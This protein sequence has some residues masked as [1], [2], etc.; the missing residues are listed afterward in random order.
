MLRKV[1]VIGGAGFIGS[2]LVELLIEN[3]FFPVVIDNFST[4]KRSNLPPGGV[5]IRDY[6]ITEDPKRL[7]GIIKG[8]ECVFHLAALTSV[9][10]SLDHPD[11]YTKVNVVGTANVLEACRIAGVKKLV[12]SST[13]AIYGNTATFPTDETQQPDPISAYALSK[14]V[15]ETYAKYYA[16][17]TEIAVTCLRY[18][19]V[20]GERTNP[21]SSYRSVIPI[22]LEQFKNG[23]PLTITNDGRQQRDF[24]YVKDVALANLKAM[25]PTRRFS[26]INIGSGKTW[27]VNQ[28]ADMISKRREN[29]G[30][31]LEPKISLA[32][33]TRAQSILGWT[34][35]TDLELWI[36]DQIV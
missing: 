34:A 36:K 23:K 1:T 3:D 10:E 16:E 13:S 6:D 2:H 26:I 8:S 21:K 30:F 25:N 24:I 35:S 7:A 27:S 32:D 15:G 29:I 5:D 9:Q 31:R 17:T 22:F 28:I 12:F 20:F 4:G 33:V 19:N 18:F 11:R 14:L